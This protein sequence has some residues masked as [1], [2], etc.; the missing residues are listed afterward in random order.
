VALD[1]AVGVTS[2][3][4]GLLQEHLDAAEAAYAAG[5]VPELAVLR[6]RLDLR[7]A[8]QDRV[9]VARD[10]ASARGQLATLM[11]RTQADVDV[12]PPEW[13]AGL[14]AGE[15]PRPVPSVDV[16]AALA[17]RPSLQ[18]AAAGVDAARRARASAAAGALPTVSVGFT[19]QW[20]N[21]T[22]FAGENAIW[23][24]TASV[25]V[26]IFDGGLRVRDVQ[27]AG[28]RIRQAEAEQEEATLAARQELRDA[29]LAAEA[30][31]TSLATARETAALA[32][33]SWEAIETAFGAG[34]ASPLEVADAAATLRG[35]ELSA[36]SEAVAV[37]SA[38]LRL[39]RAQGSPHPLHAGGAR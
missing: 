21:I 15:A 24:A 16:D 17:T 29:A 30:A 9:R 37:A 27:E 20:A 33:R 38:D 14:L 8:E 25:G 35:A 31:R 4:V 39:A 3:H 36:L 2:D 19:Y 1:R 12:V 22:G 32:R 28:A 34:A 11:G 26:P 23:A 13:L 5:A 7:T 6:A 18:A 10:A